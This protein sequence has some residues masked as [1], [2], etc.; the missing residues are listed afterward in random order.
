M[1]RGRPLKS[2]EARSVALCVRIPHT[3]IRQLRLLAMRRKQ[4]QA[5]VIIAALANELRFS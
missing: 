2:G 3:T 5:D 1:K 4:S